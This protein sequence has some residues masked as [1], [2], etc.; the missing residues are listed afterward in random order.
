MKLA[1]AWRR[2]G[3]CLED[4]SAG[5]AYQDFCVNSPLLKALV[6]VATAAKEIEPRAEDFDDYSTQQ[7]A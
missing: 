1:K 3:R 5:G 7:F 6:A 4:G 2:C